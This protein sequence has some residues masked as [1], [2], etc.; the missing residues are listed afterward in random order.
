MIGIGV[1]LVYQKLEGN[2]S[3]LDTDA[4]L[5]GDRPDEVAVDRPFKPLNILLI[6]SDSRIG[7][8]VGGDS[9]GLSDTTILLHISG[10]R[11]RAYGVSLPRDSMVE[12]P[13]CPTKDG[14]GVVPAPTGLS[15]FNAAFAVGGPACTIKT[16]EH[17]TD[18]RINHFVEVN[19]TGFRHMVDAL[20]GVPICVPEEVNDTY[21][22][23]HLEAGSYEADGRQ[24]LDYVRTRTAISDNGDIGRMRRQQAFLAAMTNK[25]V[26]AGTLA[27]PVRLYN[28]LDAATKSIRL[29][30]DL[31]SLAKL[32]GLAKQL[33]DIGLD[34][35][36]FLSVP[37]ETWSEDANRLI[38]T[39]DAEDLWEKIR[40]D[41]PLS[42]RLSEDV[43]TAA[44]A[45]TQRT[46]ARGAGG[47]SDS[48]DEE[49]VEAAE[50]PTA[51]ELER[52]ARARE[53]GLCA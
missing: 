37:F 16:V 6:G 32:A 12:R 26:S 4:L 20:D 14:E 29:D 10:D 11:Q 5:G 21:G 24:A 33:T 35:V 42:R 3:A 39:D 17:L 36:Q 18:I 25:A 28:F 51:A 27:N 19:F 41:Q 1:T 2:L 31:D 48:P 43:I 40:A 13:E 9:A 38:W 15:M 7:T 44:D 30:E 46:P 8:G 23:I 22:K 45:P 50:E 34:N 47:G 49:Q 52:A 53:N